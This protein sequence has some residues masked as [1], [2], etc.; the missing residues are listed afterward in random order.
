[1]TIDYATEYGRLHSGTK[2]FSGYSI[3]RSLSTITALVQSCRPER[4]L[5]YGC[6]KGYQY[7]KKRVHESWGGPLPECYDVGVHALSERPEGKFDFIIC[8]DMMEHIAEEDVPNILRDIASF[9]NPGAT[10]FFNIATQPARRKKLSDGR[11]V[12]LTVRPPEWW[13]KIILKSGVFDGINVV[14]EYNNGKEVA[15]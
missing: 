11:N 10:V 12:H 9:C 15:Q 14:S 2:T 7:L 3:L 4:I 13:N 1:M 5:D 8:T 6:G